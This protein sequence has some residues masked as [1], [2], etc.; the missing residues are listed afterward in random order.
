MRKDLRS[1]LIL[2]IAILVHAGLA[3]PSCATAQPVS[4]APSDMPRVG[5]VDERFN[6]YNVEMA[7][8]IGGTFWK[9]YKEP[10][11]AARKQTVATGA[12]RGTGDTRTPMICHFCAYWLMGLPLGAWLCFRLHWGPLGLWV[13]LS[14]SLILIGILLLTFWRRRLRHFPATSS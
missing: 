8:I 2:A 7:E 3:F 9:P 6:S 14:A 1:V 13:G 4:L 11:K 5:T 10:D 12:L